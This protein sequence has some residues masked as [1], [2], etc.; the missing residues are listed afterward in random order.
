VESNR[1][2]KIKC[3]IGVSRSRIK[4]GESTEPVREVTFIS[5]KVASTTGV[6]D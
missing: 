2:G 5:G 6:L 1:K 4:G 3:E